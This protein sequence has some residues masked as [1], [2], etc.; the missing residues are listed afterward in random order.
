M[1][2]LK[3]KNTSPLATQLC[4]IDTT[5]SLLMAKRL[6]C[7]CRSLLTDLADEEHDWP[8]STSYTPHVVKTSYAM[9]HT[10]Q[11]LGTLQSITERW[12]EGGGGGGGERERE[13]VSQSVS[14]W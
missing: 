8:L 2:V 6:S 7:T 1:C 5:E 4:I 13:K 9:L 10:Q 12:R 3:N 11:Q 14:K